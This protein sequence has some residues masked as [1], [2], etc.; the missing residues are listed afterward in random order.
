MTDGERVQALLRASKDFPYFIEQIFSESKDILKHGVWTHGAYVNDIATWMQNNP[1]TMRVSAK[2]HMKSM[3]F[4]AHIMQ[5]II[6]L[7]FSQ[8]SREIN[9]FS[10]KQ[11]M[12]AYHIA[13][14]KTAVECNPWF[15][16]IIDQK[17]IAESAISYSWDGEH[18][19]TVNAKGLL[20]FK[21]GI[22]CPDVYVDD[23]LQD[24]ENKMIPT[25]I[26]RINDV[27]KNQI[28]DMAQEELH[29]V[30]TAQT[31]SDFFFDQNLTSRF[32]VRI[33][34]AVISDKERKVLWPEWMNYD[35]LMA[36]KKERGEKVFNQEYL[37][38]PVYA[39]NAYLDKEKLLATVVATNKN[40]TFSEWEKEIE[41]REKK[42][43][44]TD[45]D[46]VA[47]WDLGKKGHPAHFSVFE[48]RKGKRIQIH[49][50]WFDHVDYNA[51]IEHIDRAIEVFGIQQVFYDATR[52]ELDMMEETGS[53]R[54]EYEG[55]HFTFKSKHSMANAFNSAIE[56]KEIEL[57]NTTRSINQYL[58]VNNDLQ[59]PATPEGHADCFWSTAL[60]FRDLEAEG[61]D[62]HFA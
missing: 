52:G 15:N 62:I 4:Y 25:K 17:I 16:G 56:K 57:L 26:N 39:E 45:W 7:Y 14:I 50:R 49:E 23:A 60:S 58:I 9:Y 35:E 18:S 12:A 21:R 59:A 41:R 31:N 8:R 1:K 20:E 37:C 28:L 30:G 36:K 11:T 48:K 24:P 53:L 19:L 13:K 40:Y 33:L 54:G 5:K 34:P 32:S 51:Q 3:S 27:I 10:Y 46:K 22:H 47:G 44:I 6:K 29:V 61:A 2:D 42:E 43:E 38:S 55:V